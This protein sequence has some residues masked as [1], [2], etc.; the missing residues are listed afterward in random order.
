MFLSYLYILTPTA[1]T[2]FISTSDD[3]LFLPIG[4]TESCVQIV[5]LEDSI[6]ENDE[7]FSVVLESTDPDVVLS[8]TSARV[9]IVDDDGKR[10]CYI[11]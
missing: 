10:F 7:V 11:S 9:T 5:L 4:P 8:P 1:F 3:L 2:D 6:V